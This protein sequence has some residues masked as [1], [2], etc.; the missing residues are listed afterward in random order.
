MKVKWNFMRLSYYKGYFFLALAVLFFSGCK[1]QKK[2]VANPPVLNEEDM[3]IQS[4]LSAYKQL[5]FDKYFFAGI[6]EKGTGNYERAAQQFEAAV[7]IDEN[8]AAAHYELGRMYM[9]LGAPDKAEEEV[10]KSIKL[11]DKNKWYR[12]LLLQ[13]AMSQRKWDVAEETLQNLSELDPQNPDYYLQLADMYGE[14]GKTGDA[15]KALDK[16][17]DRFGSQE[18][19]IL[20]KH[21]LYL[22]D[23]QFNKAEA[24]IQKLIKANPTEN[25]YKQILA[26][27]YIAEGNPEKAFEI[28]NAILAQN[29]DDAQTQLFVADYYYQK[30]DKVNGLATL[31]KAFANPGLDIDSKIKILYTNYL[32]KND[33]DEAGRAEAND[34]AEILVKAHPNDAKAHAI[35]GDFLYQDKKYSE[36]RDA[37]RKSIALQKDVF[38]V[39][40]QLFLINAELHD[41]Q[42]QEKETEQAMEYFPSQP[43]VYFF[44]G[45]A[46]NELKK[47]KEAIGA[48]ETGLSMTVDNPSLEI[49]FYSNLAES[50]YRL[51]HYSEMD[52]YFDKALELDPTNSLVLNNYAYYLSER[53]EKLDK[54]EEMSRLSL[55]KEPDNSSYLDTYGWIRYKQGNYKEA[56]EY[57]GKAMAIEKNSPDVMEHYG[58]ILY[59]LGRLD[60]AVS[61]WEKA[62]KAGGDSPNLSKK[63]AD[64]KLYE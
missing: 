16:F 41:A 32:M 6:N 52:T 36:A 9:Q 29:P 4:R 48:F 49:Q 13:A 38:A 60:E 18:E 17:E 43:A 39:W 45:I 31:K 26:E 14:R 21:N 23:K 40:Q 56:E 37:Y 35:H 59:K 34:L 19:V 30:G 42:A 61:Y 7:K 62:K 33:L 12:V 53:G 50:H 57:V 55:K 2:T 8:S 3:A 58:D 22:Q 20:R 10:R 25:R 5:E 44:N 64:K 47:Y 46:K 27:T 54:A 63:I 11:D 24:E 1:T 51:K 28:Y 15:I